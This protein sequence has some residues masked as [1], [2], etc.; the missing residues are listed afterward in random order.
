MVTRGQIHL[1]PVVPAVRSAAQPALRPIAPSARMVSPGL[2]LELAKTILY[3]IVFVNRS[4]NRRL[5]P[6]T[7]ATA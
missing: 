7:S 1:S 2:A 3:Q 6:A 4:S 5:L